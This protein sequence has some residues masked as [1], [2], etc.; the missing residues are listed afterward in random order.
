MMALL[1]FA[2]GADTRTYEDPTTLALLLVDIHLHGWGFEIT[3][4]GPKKWPFRA[5]VIV[6][7]SGR[8]FVAEADTVLGAARSAFFAAKEALNTP[9]EAPQAT[10]EARQ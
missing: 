10:Q 1:D 8:Q 2:A 3:N 4:D 5:E 7:G 9:P 6:P